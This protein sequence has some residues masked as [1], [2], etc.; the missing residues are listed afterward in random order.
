MFSSG[1]GTST[2]R[3]SRRLASRASRAPSALA[4]GTSTPLAHS[5]TLP[6][7]SRLLG[8]NLAATSR[9]LAASPAPGSRRATRS[10]VAR[11]VSEGGSNMEVDEQ[12]QG[13]GQHGN[14][15]D[16]DKVLVK[17]EAYAIT[18]RKGLPQEVEQAVASADA[19]TSPVK[20]VLDPATG[21]ALL[22]N[23]EHCFVWN[24]SQRTGSTTTYVFPVPP[25]APL[26][27][28]V[29]AYSPLPFATLVPSAS[30]S[31]LSSQR[32]P[33]LLICSNT[34]VI[35]FWEAVS[36]SLSGVDRFKSARA[37]LQDGELIR[38]LH[39]VAPATY[40]ASTS[41]A[42]V[43]AVCIA[44]V[45]GRAE[46]AVR[47]LERQVGWAGSVWSAVFGS[48]KTV[49]PRAG[50]LALAVA[51]PK[52]AGAET[53]RTVY[54]VMEKTVQVWSVPTRGAESGGERL[55]VE[56]DLFH[57]VLEALAGEKVGN[58]QWALN[59]GEVEVVDA[60]VTREGQLAVLVS[61][62]HEGTVEGSRSF[63]VVSLAVGH[64]QGAVEVAGVTHLGYQ[65]RP[66]PRPLS[67]PR[68]TLGSSDVA[69]V[70]FADAVV[71]ASLANDSSFEESFPL[72]STAHRI[73]GHSLPSHLPNPTSSTS[74][75]SLLTSTPSLL[76][77]SVTAPR[78]RALA[79]SS[80]GLKT[81]KL[82]TRLEQAV[83]FGT[84]AGEG[85]A[86]NPLAF[87]LHPGYEGDLAKAAEALSA[88]ILASS[89]PNMPFIL[90]L[91]AQL[92]DRAHR[93][94]A[95]IE[96][97]AENGLLDKL[98][99][100][101]RLQLSWDAERL[102]AAVALW[103]HQ[104]ARLNAPIAS[105]L[106]DAVLTYMDEVGEGFGEDPLRLF[107]RTKI[108]ALGA[109]L[110]EVSKQA[111]AAVESTAA[112]S[113]E[114]SVHLQEANQILLLAFNALTRHRVDTAPLYN[115]T[116]S[117]PLEPW[118]SRPALLDA[119][120]LHFDAT[121]ALLR[122]RVRDFGAQA[123]AAAGGRYGDL[124]VQ[125]GAQGMQDELKR[126]MAALAEHVFNA[127]EER[128]VFLETVAG[129][130]TTPEQRALRER[131][132]ALR[133]QV[134]RTLVSVGKVPAAFQLAE[135]HH[136]FS[137][138]VELALDAT[139]GSPAKVKR[140]LDDYA[141]AFAFPLY[142]FYLDK[143]MTRALLEPE[144][145]HQELVT[146]FLDQTG[147]T[148]LAWINDIAIDRYDH[149]TEALVAEA[150]QEV[151]LAQKKLELSLSKLT[152]LASLDLP[153]LQ[154]EPVQR[155]L[156]AVDDSLDLVNSQDGL[157]TLF[158][159][160]LSG[161]E[162]HLVAEE[163]GLAVTERVAP[164][165]SNRPAFAQQYAQLA[166]QLFAG[167]A[168]TA[169]DLI[170]LFTLKENVGEQSGDFATALDVLVR[171]KELPEARKKV[172]LESIWRRVYIQDDWRSLKDATGL[173]DEEMADAL[174]NTAFYATLTTAAGSSHPQSL[175]LEPSQCFSS[176]TAD[177][178]AARY[179]DAPRSTLDAL[180]ADYQ[181][182]DAV[183]SNCLQYDGLEA[184]AKE[185]LRILQEGELAALEE[186]DASMLVE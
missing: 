174:R 136:D 158:E 9:S 42:R 170:D 124:S 146:A 113:E 76:T 88:E 169:E 137:S 73:I 1:A 160:L 120:Q 138:L 65:A 30:S 14:G 162:T 33:G 63:A 121:D 4:S 56:Q 48:G 46:L 149:A 79:P 40:L 16:Q 50:I 181:Q 66:D 92:A 164:A 78:T 27:P 47:P 100:L 157:A 117:L 140:F 144:E 37:P 97:I 142:R 57:G 77:V 12:G 103:H 82:Q 22:V 155:A 166:G 19:Y 41:H 115:L 173:R 143:G 159:S 25:Q 179:P 161:I 107:F 89:S 122:E 150:T 62:R 87:E 119:L 131:Y 21:F 177:E 148:K 11:S 125:G 91:R 167:Q 45:G 75:L 104:N 7:N 133:P 23:S 109:V 94:R 175:Y 8:D 10:A 34:G 127:C 176:A 51:P 186:E 147:N 49:D 101:T 171:A 165:L 64:A 123:Q 71:I 53:E 28:N 108:G 102:A 128:L 52:S 17:D 129:E 135:Q 39:P 183:L 153:S 85:D 112:G 54:A 31:S 74:T 84:K 182:E 55:V 99:Q 139:H 20:A 95:L 5:P 81:R 2:P 68:L 151:A 26:P 134:I 80:E 36:L 69:F 58:E 83:F 86:E 152:R 126:Q 29:T 24:W 61:H 105:P 96:F 43:L 141:D 154:S 72:R 110:E 178:L 132:L 93:A 6:S 44:S 90:D 15:K 111:K 130:A 185:V 13:Q 67:T 18:E 38:A 114:K 118:S 60:A 168:L 70:V 116:D 163:K 59:Q 3:Q 35:R 145:E 156:E 184:Y 180:L 32:E 106:A 98:P 172:A